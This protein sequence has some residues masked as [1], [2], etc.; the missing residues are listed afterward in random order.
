[1]NYGFAATTKQC[2]ALCRETALS[3]G[4]SAILSIEK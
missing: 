2:W 1:M 4:L 3:D